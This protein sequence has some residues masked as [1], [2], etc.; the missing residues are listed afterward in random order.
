MSPFPAKKYLR[1]GYSRIC[2][3]ETLKLLTDA[4]RR[5]DFLHFLGGL[6]A[7]LINNIQV[8]KIKNKDI[9]KKHK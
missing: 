9:I 3:R 5:D 7:D 4:D 1:A 8:F 2:I 6:G